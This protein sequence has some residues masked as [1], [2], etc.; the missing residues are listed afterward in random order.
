MKLKRCPVPDCGGEA[1]PCSNSQLVGCLNPECGMHTGIKRETWQRLPRSA[2]FRQVL[3]RMKPYLY[4]GMPMPDRATLTGW[5]HDLL[6]T[7][8]DCEEL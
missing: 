7:C 4:V 6:A 3:A 8:S 2:A 5:Y 1:A